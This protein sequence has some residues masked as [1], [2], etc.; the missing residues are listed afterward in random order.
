MQK[1]EYLILELDIVGSFNVFTRVNRVN[2]EFL[3]EKPKFLDHL[4]ELGNQG[5]ELVSMRDKSYVIFKRP[6]E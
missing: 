4:L 5:W 1:W 6:T 2:G 3:K